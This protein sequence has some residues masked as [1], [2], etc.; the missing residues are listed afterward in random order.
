MMHWFGKKDH[1]VPVQI[2]GNATI[3]IRLIFFFDLELALEHSE[4]KCKVLKDCS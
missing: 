3:W 4:G 1:L 2:Y